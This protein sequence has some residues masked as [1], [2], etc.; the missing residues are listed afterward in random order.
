MDSTRR[1]FIHQVGTSVAGAAALGVAPELALAQTAQRTKQAAPA[2]AVPTIIAVYLRGGADALGVIVPFA[3]KH[4]VGHRPTL[5]IAGP[6]SS[7]VNRALPLD[8]QLG[9]NPN[10]QRLHA[11]YEKGMV[12]PIVCVGSPDATRSHFDAQDFMERGAPGMKNIATGWLNRYLR[13]TRTS[14]DAN[15]R[16]VSLQSLL[17][18]S[19]RGD[20]PVLAQPDA[21]ADLAMSTYN[22]LYPKGQGG[23]MMEMSEDSDKPLKS[24]KTASRGQQTKRAIQEFGARTIEQLAEMN[25]ILEKSPDP[26]VRYPQGGFGRQMSDIAKLIKANRGLEVTAIDIGGWDHHINEAPI[27]GQL[28]RMLTNLSNTIGAFVEDLGAERMQ[29]VLVVIMSEF[30][31]TVR[32]NDN[33][34][35]DHGHGG[36]MLAIG[37]KIA[38]KKVYGKWTGL[39]PDQLY[40]NRDL[41]VHTDFRVVFAESLKGLFKFDGIKEGLFPQYTPNSP[42]LGLMG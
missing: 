40:E 30:G 27:D 16:A 41:P 34:G 31:R 20:Y 28:G 35:T 25:T 32:E 6:D 10:M 23:A 5:A 12:A 22:R 15:L 1:E 37:G 42:P 29:K 14:R 13:E 24:S 18:R 4:L 2:Q 38:G 17:P 11:L 8:G 7:G 19:L 36:F 39:A 21:K 33:R 9:F 3:D 26:T